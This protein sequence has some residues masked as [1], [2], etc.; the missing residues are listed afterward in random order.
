MDS[1]SAGGDPPFTFKNATQIQ[2]SNSS[3]IKETLV[4]FT[5]KNRGVPGFSESVRR[6]P[7]VLPETK[8]LR[9]QNLS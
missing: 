8:L 2:D 4:V 3:E 5:K 6:H 9:I 1:E 7:E